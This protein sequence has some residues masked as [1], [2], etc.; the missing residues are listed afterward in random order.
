MKANPQQIR[1]DKQWAHTAPPIACRFDPS[2][3]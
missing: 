3:E 2:G 1:I